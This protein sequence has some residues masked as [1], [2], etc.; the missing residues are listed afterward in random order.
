MDLR[1]YQQEAVNEIEQL[2]ANGVKNVMYVLPCRGGKTPIAATLINNKK[3][4]YKVAIAHRSNLVAQM[5]RTLARNGIYHNIIANAATRRDCIKAQL[6]EFGINYVNAQAVTIVASVGTLVKM[7]EPWFADVTLWLVDEGHHL[8]KDNQWGRVVDK[9]PLA[10]GLALTATPRR[11][12]RKGLGRS[13]HGV[14]DALVEGPTASQLLA[15]GFLAP[16]RVVIPT[17]SIDTTGI[18]LSASGDFSPVPLA[19]AAHKSSIVKD[20]VAAY[21]QFC[22]G[23][24]AVVF[25]VDV[26][27]AEKQREAFALA[28]ISAAMLCGET[29]ILEQIKIQQLHQQR[30][31]NV[32]CNVDLYGEG[33]DIPDLEVVVLGRPTQSLSLHI[34]QSMRPLNP[35]PGK[36][37]LIID[38]VGNVMKHGLPNTEQI[39]SLESEV[40][41]SS[42]VLVRRCT[43]PTCSAV[44]ERVLG[45]VCPFCGMEAIPP[46]KRPTIVM[47]AVEEVTGNFEELSPEALL[48]LLG[49]MRKVLQEPRIP[50]G[51]TPEIRGAI[52][53]RHRE[54]LVALD[55]LKT[56]MAVW[57]TGMLDLPYARRLFYLTFGVDVA[58]AQGLPR[59]DMILLT[60]RIEKCKNQM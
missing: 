51:A 44:Y 28:G 32:I 16:F 9:F 58:T 42:T 34:Q 39:W 55:A 24:K 60:E 56:A 49:P 45:P 11:A 1:D 5:S 31:I 27:T 10:N 48:E 19:E 38:V 12:D 22:P 30:V 15:R 23:A 53:K 59:K 8:T 4:G 20:V 26:D 6:K 50:A 3:T 17:I 37:A 35:L 18:P 25:C 52:L 57:A 47:D 43:N 54:H 7:N 40:K 36:I 41:N 29:P 2:W 21:Q 33:V 13:S 46:I 14:I